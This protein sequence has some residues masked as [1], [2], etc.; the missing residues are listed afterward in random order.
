MSNDYGISPETL[1]G[2]IHTS[3]PYVLTPAEGQARFR[4]I[5]QDANTRG[6]EHYRELGPYFDLCVSAHWASAGSFCPTDVDNAIRGHLWNKPATRDFVEGM[7]KT[8]EEALGWDYAGVT[9]KI[10]APEDRALRVSTHEGTWFSVAVGAYGAARKLGNEAWR[11][12]FY[13][14]IATE[15]EREA[16]IAQHWYDNDPFQFV[17]LGPLI[18]HNLG[19]FDRVVEAWEL[20][21]DDPLREKFYELGE[22]PGSLFFLACQFYKKYL[23]AD[24]HRH[25]ALRTPKCLRRHSELLL[26]I[27]PFHEEW[28]ALIAKTPL[29]S[30]REKAEVA[31][32][33]AD[34]WKRLKGD[35]WGY[36]RA[37]HGFQ[38]AMGRDMRHVQECWSAKELK[39]VQD[40][41]FQTRVKMPVSTFRS[42]YLR[43]LQGM[44]LHG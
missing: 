8:T 21:K 41:A 25:F 5:L 38:E 15:M 22:K 44:G 39:L 9:N 35:T 13:D 18:S 14:Q 33:L 42:R 37:F 7:W 43:A 30:L 20:P 27:G 29:L 32:E 19:D 11:Q 24:G 34:G 28:G 17:R 31:L 12:R 16:A 36:A 4:S 40:A 23:S 26:G 3:C 1:L 6:P 10:V 2:Q